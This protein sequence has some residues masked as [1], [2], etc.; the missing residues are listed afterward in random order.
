MAGVTRSLNAATSYDGN[1]P[2]Y[3]SAGSYKFIP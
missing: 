1:Y 2:S 3:D